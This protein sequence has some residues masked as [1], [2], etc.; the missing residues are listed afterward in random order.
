MI[1][2]GCNQNEP[3]ERQLFHAHRKQKAK[4]TNKHTHTHTF[5]HRNMKRATVFALLLALFACAAVKSVNAQT[6]EY[7]WNEVSNVTQWEE[8][9]VPVPHEDPES[10]KKYYVDPKTGESVWEVR[11]A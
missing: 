2:R 7:F 10:G 1:G 3:N 4:Q 8:P 9:A 5:A 11:D 6:R